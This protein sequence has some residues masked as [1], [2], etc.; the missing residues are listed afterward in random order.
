MNKLKSNEDSQETLTNYM[1]QL[2]LIKSK[3]LNRLEDKVGIFIIELNMYMD[4]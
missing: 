1:D 2:E 4:I 3:P